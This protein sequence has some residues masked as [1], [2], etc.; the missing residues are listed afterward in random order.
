MHEQHDDN[1]SANDLPD[2]VYL[3]DV[4]HYQG[5]IDGSEALAA[6][7]V[8]CI[9]KAT[10]GQ[11]W[12]QP[13][14]VE[15]ANAAASAGM[16]L[17]F[18]HYATLGVGGAD[19]AE[20]EADDFL[21]AIADL[22]PAD[23]PLWLDLEEIKGEIS[24][25]DAKAWVTTW[26]DIVDEAHPGGAGLYTS[27]RKVRDIIGD[28][29]GLEN[30]AY[31]LPRYGSNDGTLEGSSLPDLPA[32]VDGWQIWQYTSKHDDPGVEKHTDRNV[33]RVDWLTS[34]PGITAG[35]LAALIG[36]TSQPNFADLP[37]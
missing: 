3:L 25:A 8:G 2:L 18:Y 16:L 23:L 13:A 5:K 33:A 12:Q 27:A 26:L 36:D 17:G 37:R 34:L 19:D 1:P 10:E 30:Y 14:L 9:V 6:G 7:N 28:V 21:A 4:N 29:S 24:K 15:Q 11:D 35:K 22:P 31:W 32:G 20:R